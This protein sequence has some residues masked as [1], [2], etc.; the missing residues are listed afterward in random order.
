[1]VVD[2]AEAD[3]RVVRSVAGSK[4]GVP[5]DAKRGGVVPCRGMGTNPLDPRRGGD[6]AEAVAAGEP[7]DRDAQ[8]QESQ[9][10]RQATESRDGRKDQQGQGHRG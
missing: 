4:G 9:E 10:E 8:E 1:M 3:R 2:H 6:A 5:G 7:K